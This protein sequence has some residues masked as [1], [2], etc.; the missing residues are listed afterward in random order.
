MM[1]DQHDNR[2]DVRSVFNDL[3]RTELADGD[4]P[5]CECKCDGAEPHADRR[6]GRRATTFVAV[7]LWGE[8]ENPDVVNPAAVDADGNL[9]CLMCGPCS[10]HAYH[11]AQA[12]VKQLAARLPSGVVPSCPACYRPT[13][14]ADDIIERRPM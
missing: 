7:H 10:L 5:G 2:D 13:V 14:S 6:C 11:V 1:S 3:V 9:T 8:C 4:G 12:R